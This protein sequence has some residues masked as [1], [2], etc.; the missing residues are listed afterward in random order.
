MIFF[1]AVKLVVLQ[2]LGTGGLSPT[3]AMEVA[4]E[5]VAHINAQSKHANVRIAGY[6]QIENA[7]LVATLDN[8]QPLLLAIRR[9]L[10][11]NRLRDKRTIFAVILPPMIKDGGVYTGGAAYFCSIARSPSLATF[12]I[13]ATDFN[14]LG[15][16]RVL[17]AKTAFAHELGHAL[18]APHDDTE[19]PTLM[20]SNVLYW[21]KDAILPLSARSKRSIRRG[22]LH[23]AMRRKLY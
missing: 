17:H 10:S 16:E 23:A 4:A 13:A 20:N 9:H 6:V 15:Q 3:L 22:W 21:V 19:P 8:Q 2:A 5:A 1:L 12:Y 14:S 7:E 18:C 11:D